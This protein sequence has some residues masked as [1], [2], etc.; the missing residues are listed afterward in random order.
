[1][2]SMIQGTFPK[3]YPVPWHQSQR[4]RMEGHINVVNLDIYATTMNRT[5]R[6][7]IMIIMILRHSFRSS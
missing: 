3:L 7:M 4:E 2:F 1:M 6:F 5:Y